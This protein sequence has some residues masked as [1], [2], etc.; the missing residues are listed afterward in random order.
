MDSYFKKTKF[1]VRSLFAIIL[2]A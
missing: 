2:Y 1:A